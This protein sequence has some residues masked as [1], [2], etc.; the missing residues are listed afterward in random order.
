MTAPFQGIV[1]V[2]NMIGFPIKSIS[3]VL[4]Y[5]DAL[6]N[7][8]LKAICCLYGESPKSAFQSDINS[9]APGFRRGDDV[10]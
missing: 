8:L 9:L 3:H 10:L 7:T 2:Y 5:V 4:P 6:A 1:K